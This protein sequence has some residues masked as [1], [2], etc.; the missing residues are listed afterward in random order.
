LDDEGEAR[1][2]VA[3]RWAGLRACDA[4][5]VITTVERIMRP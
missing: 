2:H 4:G 5:G 1:P 3:L